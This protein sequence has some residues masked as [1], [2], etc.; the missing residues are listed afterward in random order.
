MVAT[1]ILHRGGGAR[2]ALRPT[3]LGP[4]AGSVP[5][6]SL[7]RRSRAACT[8]VVV[9]VLTRS[10]TR[11]VS[12]TVRISTQDSAGAPG[13]FCVDADISLSGRKM[14]RPGPRVGVFVVVLSCVC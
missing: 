3:C 5:G 13:L 11:P 9:C 14:P 8:M 6:G 2:L 7:R 12:S 10:L 4:R 1:A